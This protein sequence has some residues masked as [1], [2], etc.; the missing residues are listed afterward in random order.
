MRKLISLVMILAMPAL[1]FGATGYSVLNSGLAS[2]DYVVGTAPATMDFDVVLSLEATGAYGF[3][4]GLNGPA[5]LT[6]TARA[7][8]APVT[9]A[10][11]LANTADAAFI[12]SNLVA[13][14]DLG[15]TETAVGAEIP[16]GN[17][18]VVT[19]TVSGIGALPI[20]DYSLVVGDSDYGAG[21]SWSNTGEPILVTSSAPFALK[22]SAPPIITPEPATMLLLTVAL[23]FLRRRSA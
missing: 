7:F 9:N 11:W 13:P 2:A 10:I 3:Y 21:A 18:T 6:I 20:G 19:L 23:P 12:G 5:G 14:L 22:I 16:A 15:S 4:G 1:A 8:K 17:T